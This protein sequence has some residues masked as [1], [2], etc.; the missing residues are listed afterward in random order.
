[1]PPQWLGLSEIRR[2]AYKMSSYSSFTCFIFMRLCLLARCVLAWP[3]RACSLVV[4]LPRKVGIKLLPLAGL[5]PVVSRWV[6]HAVRSEERRVG[7]EGGDEGWADAV[8][9][10]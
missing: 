4:E 1:M 10:G 8:V 6:K 2:S 3:V 9:R 7:K 5:L